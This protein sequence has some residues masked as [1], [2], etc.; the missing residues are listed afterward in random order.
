MRKYLKKQVVYLQC[1]ILLQIYKFLGVPKYELDWYK[2]R[3]KLIKEGSVVKP[4]EKGVT[5]A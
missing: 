1:L 3:L 4:L 5:D 2:A